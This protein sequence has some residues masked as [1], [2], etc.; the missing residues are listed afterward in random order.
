MSVAAVPFF[1]PLPVRLGLGLLRLATAGRPERDQA[2]ALIH[3]ALDRG[4][5]ILDTA[6]SYCLDNGDLH[7]GEEL[8]RDALAA[9]R[10]PRDEVR[11]LTKVG[12]TRPKGRWLPNSRPTHLRKAVQGS[13]KALGV[14]RLFL[15]QLHARDPGTPFEETLAALAELQR[16]GLIEH[17]GLCNVSSAEVR[18]AQR[19]FP[20]VVVQN[21]LS[22][23]QRDTAEAGLVAF[24][25][26][27]GIPFLAHRPLGGHAKVAKLEKN[28]VLAPLAKRHGVS[29]HQIALAA[30]LEAGP[31]VLPLIGAT[32]PASLLDSLAATRLT[33]DATD[34][35]ALAAKH[36]LAPAPEALAELLRPAPAP[37][38]VALAS[39]VGPGDDPEVVLI[40]GIQGAGKSRLV[41]AYVDHGYVRLNRDLLGGKL[42]DLVP[43]LKQLLA[44]GQRRVVLDNT[45]PTRLSRAPVIAAAHAYGVPVRCRHLQTPLPEAQVNIVLRQIE[46]YGKLLSPEE[47]K[48]LAK[49]DPN[50]P[51]P[52]ALAR[53]ASS[54]EPPAADEGFAA[55]DAVPFQRQ[56][57]PSHVNKGLLLDVDGTL[58][59]TRSGEI[60]PRHPD[61]VELLPGR[62]D[63]LARWVEAGY[64][65][66]FISNQSGVASGK[67]E[68]TA[69][70]AA[71]LRTAELLALPVA[72]VA[73]CPHAAFPVGCY[74]RKPMP[75]LGVHLM[76]RHQLARSHLTMVGD[77]ESDA[78]FAAALGARYFAAEEFFGLHRPEPE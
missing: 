1:G 78:Q 73:Y 46:K 4:V 61:D 51:P 33:L 54:F 48:A 66:F 24:T 45:Y 68:R 75:G 5:R 36:S 71:L 42:D 16:E 70:E 53:W 44:A 7:Y 17:L 30:V 28:R 11:I 18:Q 65:L 31:H 49:V 74:C 32:R 69:V 40:M 41:Q 58:R 25:A 3:L 47:M 43:R 62:R 38:P 63:V 13:L 14:E 77:M 23:L 29:P 55:V 19:H 15:V 12:L 20:V 56:L 8:A 64:R 72:E 59:R 21:E 60:Y 22:I 67:V 35:Q 9:W 6:D 37:P 39:N 57:D 10:G 2:I 26:L 34:R 27:A 50:L 76:Q 52:A